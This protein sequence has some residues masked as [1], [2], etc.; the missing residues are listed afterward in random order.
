MRGVTFGVVGLWDGV[1][2]EGA[3]STVL[4]DWLGCDWSAVTTTS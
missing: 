3:S 1:V 4:R 2:F